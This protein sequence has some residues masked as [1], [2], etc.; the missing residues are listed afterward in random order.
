M[1]A[2]DF[3]YASA[4]DGET[5]ILG[6]KLGNLL[7]AGDV[8]ALTGELGSGKTCF[9]KGLARGLGV[10]ADVVVNSPS[11][12]LLNEYDDGRVTFYHLDAYRLERRDDFLGAGLDEVFHQGGVVALEWGDRWPEILPDWTVTAAFD[13]VDDTSRNIRFSARHPRS[14]NILIQ[15][16]QQLG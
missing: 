3:T 16:K 13:M 2:I 5:R 10:P 1:S 12:A 15:L 7:A 4:S 11:F 9:A 14:E 6:R 8:V